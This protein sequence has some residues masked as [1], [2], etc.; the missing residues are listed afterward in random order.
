MSGEV[1]QSR[2]GGG[3]LLGTARTNPASRLGAILQASVQAGG[4]PAAAY[5]EVQEYG[6][7]RVYEICPVNKQAL[8]FFPLGSLGSNP[9][10]NL[11]PRS[12]KA[13]SGYQRGLR[14]RQKSGER[15][16]TLKPESYGKFAELG[17]VVVKHV[18]HPP[19]PERSYMRSALEEMRGEI[20][21][22]IHE[23]AAKALQ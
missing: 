22:R 8:A 18:H 13:E 23:A 16:G 7:R 9:Q 15:R 5:G 4:G 17:G 20:I 10:K 2:R 11:F 3:G 12:G 19:L 21:A 1:L 6:G 14:L